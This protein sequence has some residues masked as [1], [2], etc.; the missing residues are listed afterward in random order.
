MERERG[1]PLGRAAAMGHAADVDHTRG[2]PGEEQVKQP[3]CEHEVA[4]K[5]C[6]EDEVVAVG[7]RLGRPADPTDTSVVDQH[8]NGLSLVSSSTVDTDA[9]G[10]ALHIFIAA[11]FARATERHARITWYACGGAAS[12][13]AT[14]NPTPQLLPVTTATRRQFMRSD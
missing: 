10:H 11:S 2:R 1:L 14:A 4:D 8:R 12:A 3:Q 13:E 5:V 6:A 9:L 7:R